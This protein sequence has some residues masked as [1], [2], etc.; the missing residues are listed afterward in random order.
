MQFEEL[1]NAGASLK[2][3]HEFVSH[4]GPACLA[5]VELLLEFHADPNAKAGKP[6]Y[7]DMYGLT[8]L[9]MLTYWCNGGS[10]GLLFQCD[11]A[12]AFDGAGRMHVLHVLHACMP[13]TAALHLLPGLSNGQVGYKVLL[14]QHVCPDLVVSPATMALSEAGSK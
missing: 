13:C 7:G 9:H 5:L 4:S 2:T 8:P 10:I 14:V 11:V 1:V 3:F 6:G 12:P